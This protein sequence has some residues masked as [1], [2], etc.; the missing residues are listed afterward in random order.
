MLTS[1]T[2]ET[3]V[4]TPL[5]RCP[6]TDTTTTS[7]LSAVTVRC[8]AVLLVMLS[9]LLSPVSLTLSCVRVP[10]ASAGTVWSTTNEVPATVLAL[11]P[12]SVTVMLGR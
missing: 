2:P 5:Y 3:V 1:Y 9:V 7:P 11:P 8:G 10:V 6:S 12:E 4:S